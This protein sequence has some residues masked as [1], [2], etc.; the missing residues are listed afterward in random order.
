M[1]NTYNTP[2]VVQPIHQRGVAERHTYVVYNSAGELWGV[3]P[4]GRPYWSKDLVM[5][6]SVST[7]A[8][9]YRDLLKFAAELELLEREYPDGRVA[10][11]L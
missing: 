2:F 7:D 8:E 4:G 9:G 5:I 11:W 10:H 3:Y 6:Q 1:F